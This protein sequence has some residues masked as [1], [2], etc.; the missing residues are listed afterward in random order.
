M[1]GKRRLASDI[2]RSAS[3]DAVKDLRRKSNTLKECVADL[4]IENRPLKKHDG[5]WE[6][7]A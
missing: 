3:T 7:G 6:A 5:E 4:T 1:T 2:V